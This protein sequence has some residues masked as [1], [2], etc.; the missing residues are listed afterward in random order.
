MINYA[1]LDLDSVPHLAASVAEKLNYQYYHEDGVTETVIFKSAALASDWYDG[2]L[3]FGFIKAEEWKRRTIPDL[4]EESYALKAVDQELGS[5]IK[6][7]QTLTGNP[8]IIIKG[9][10]SGSGRKTKDIDGLQDRYQFNRYKCRETWTP[11]DRKVHMD[12]CR[13]YMLG[14]YDWIKLG[15]PGLEADAIVI[16]FAEK[17]G[18]N[19]VMGIKDKDLKQSLNT[20]YID[21]NVTPPKRTLE[22]TTVLGQVHVKVMARNRKDLGGQGMKLVLAQGIAG[23]T[24]DGYKGLKGVGAVAAVELL[25][26]LKTVDACIS[27]VLDL[28]HT[29]LPDGIEYVDWNGVAQKR[30]AEQLAIQHCQLAYH[31][32]GPK[33]VSNPIERFINNEAQLFANL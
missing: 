22:K 4:K 23:D 29:K 16:H 7:I 28:Y 1:Y 30:T 27:A 3:G 12:A 13:N 32:R 10:L 24:A 8:G 6:S 5:W 31:E 20:H 19:A 2:E 15:P 11:I 14:T 33:D 21:M 9:F 18:R 17:R 25:N 26:D